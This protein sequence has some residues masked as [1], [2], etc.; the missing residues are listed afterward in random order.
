M[1]GLSTW[2]WTPALFEAK[3]PVCPD[4]LIFQVKKWL[5]E[6]L[7]LLHNAGVLSHLQLAEDGEESPSTPARHEGDV[8]PTFPSLGI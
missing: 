2:L 6:H 3:A 1:E 7:N 5:F 8:D 4:K